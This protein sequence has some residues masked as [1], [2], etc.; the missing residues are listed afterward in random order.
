MNPKAI[1]HHRKYGGMWFVVHSDRD[2]FSN[3]V[4]DYFMT[5]HEAQVA[6]AN[7]S[8]QYP[9]D[10]LFIIRHRTLEEAKAIARESNERHKL[11]VT[12]YQVAIRVPYQGKT[13]PK[14]ISGMIG[15]RFKA[16]RALRSIRRTLPGALLVQ[17]TRFYQDDELTGRQEHLRRIIR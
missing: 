8:G 5:E 10:Q 4:S 15:S 13:L 16:V 6:K 2:M 7:L 17:H 1:A 14:N 9:A 3:A 12:Y 11:D